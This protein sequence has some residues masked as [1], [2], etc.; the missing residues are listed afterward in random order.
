MIYTI[1]NPGYVYRERAII[2]YI[3]HI[4]IIYTT[5]PK[6]TKIYIRMYKIYSIVYTE[7]YTCNSY[8]SSLKNGT[9]FLHK[10]SLLIHKNI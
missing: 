3:I 6:N 4:P 2:Y 7:S 10:I 9:N 5:I 8:N 1:H